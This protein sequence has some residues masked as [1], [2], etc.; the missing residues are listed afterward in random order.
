M[1][2]TCL[3]SQELCI[4]LVQLVSFVPN[5]TLRSTVGSPP[6]QKKKKKKRDICLIP[7]CTTASGNGN[8]VP[9]ANTVTNLATAEKKV[10]G[11]R[12]N[13][14]PFQPN[15]GSGG[16]SSFV[17]GQSDARTTPPEP[18]VPCRRKQAGRAPVG[19]ASW[20]GLPPA[21]CRAVLSCSEEDTAPRLV[22]GEDM[23]DTQCFVWLP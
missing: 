14:P 3:H 8:I 20:P 12:S 17:G 5:R 15:L 13:G 1:A 9:S 19:L 10:A 21:A 18:G 23:F 11:Q 2:P 22:W 7:P 16:L 4:S 6:R